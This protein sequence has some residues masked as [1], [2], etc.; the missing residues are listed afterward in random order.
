MDGIPL[1]KIIVLCNVLVEISMKYDIYA[2]NL[3]SD[4]YG[5]KGLGAV[6]DM[7][8]IC[9]VISIMTSYGFTSPL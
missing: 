5:H 4:M 8:V 6:E 7:S 3:P 1:T 2:N 9:P